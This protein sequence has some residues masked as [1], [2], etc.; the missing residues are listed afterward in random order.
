[1]IHRVYSDLATFKPLNFRGGLNVILAEK[2]QGASDRQTRNRAGKSSFVEMLHFL[3]GGNADP[4]SLFRTEALE[5]FRFGMEFDVA[6]Q[7]VGVER[8]GKSGSK[9][10]VRAEDTSAWPI[11]PPPAHPAAVVEGYGFNFS[12]IISGDAGGHRDVAVQP[13]IGLKHEV[14]RRR[15]PPQ[16]GSGH[17]TKRQ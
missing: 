9:I 7:K 5:S 16:P 6:G 17:G 15:R 3:L 4:K 13:R 2:S 11:A 14:R 12:P 10:T 1:M 8:S